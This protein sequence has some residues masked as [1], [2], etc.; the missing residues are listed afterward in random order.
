M[1][2]KYCKVP[3]KKTKDG[4]YECNLCGFALPPR[5]G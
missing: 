1:K 5:K 3:M 2:C 4:Y